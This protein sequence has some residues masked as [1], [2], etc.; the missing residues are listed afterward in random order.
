M[1]RS[2]EVVDSLLPV[3]SLDKVELLVTVKRL[4]I[5]AAIVLLIAQLVIVTCRFV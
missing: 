1:V 5:I 3:I 2:V 4:L